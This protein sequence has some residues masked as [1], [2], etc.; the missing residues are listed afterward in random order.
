MEDEYPEKSFEASV[1]QT[2]EIAIREVRLK[3]FKDFTITL[4]V[5][6]GFTIQEITRALRAEAAKQLSCKLDIVSL[7]HKIIRGK[8]NVFLRAVPLSGV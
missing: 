4:E 3:H 8:K 5:S 2:A 6:S 7:P 1:E